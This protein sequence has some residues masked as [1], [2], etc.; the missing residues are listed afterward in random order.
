MGDAPIG[1]VTRAMRPLAK[2]FSASIFPSKFEFGAFCF[3]LLFFCS[4]NTPGSPDP[5]NARES[6]DKLNVLLIVADD[7]NLSLIHI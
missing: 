7:M 5:L 1:C 4:C 2:Y 3:F 6:T